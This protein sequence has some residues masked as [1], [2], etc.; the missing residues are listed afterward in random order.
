MDPDLDLQFENAEPDPAKIWIFESTLLL[1]IRI[2][3]DHKNITFSDDFLEFLRKK[4]C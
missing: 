3:D 1:E 2:N 4:V